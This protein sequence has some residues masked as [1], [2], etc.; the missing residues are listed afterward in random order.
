MH[1]MMNSMGGMMWGTGLFGLVILVL[2]IIAALFK[3][4]FFLMKAECARPY[5]AMSRR[6]NFLTI[7]IPLAAIKVS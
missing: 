7:I 3:H 1:E 5:V 4:V 6:P 2:L